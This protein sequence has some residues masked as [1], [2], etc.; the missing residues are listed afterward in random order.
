MC[1]L[2]DYQMI[3]DKV[4]KFSQIHVSIWGCFILSFYLLFLRCLLLTTCSEFSPVL[5]HQCPLPVQLYP[6]VSPLLVRSCSENDLMLW[7]TFNQAANLLR[8]KCSMK[9]TLR[10]NLFL[11][12]S[13]KN[14]KSN[15]LDP[16]T[17]MLNLK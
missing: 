8:N 11:W 16:T 1:C 13:C 7:Q 9:F 2:T 6:S 5:P 4:A 15:I 14:L 10:P 17:G 3:F 12:K